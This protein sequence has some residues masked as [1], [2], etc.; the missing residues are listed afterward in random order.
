MNGSFADEKMIMV[1]LDFM[2]LINRMS[3]LVGRQ[4]SLYQ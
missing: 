1:H 2:S 4:D 3:M